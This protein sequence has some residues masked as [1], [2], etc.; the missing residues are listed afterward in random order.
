MLKTFLIV[1]VK[2]LLT[3]EMLKEIDRGLIVHD[4]R[5]DIQIG[6]VDMTDGVESKKINT[7]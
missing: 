6:V 4:E 5:L 3:K 7:E 2:T 1:K